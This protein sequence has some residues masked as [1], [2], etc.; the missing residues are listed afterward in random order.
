[1]AAVDSIHANDRHLFTTAAEAIADNEHVCKIVWNSNGIDIA[2]LVNTHRTNIDKEGTHSKWDVRAADGT[3]EKIWFLIVYELV[4][5]HKGNNETS[6]SAHA[7]L[8]GSVIRP[9][10]TSGGKQQPWGIYSE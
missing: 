8:K 9:Q 2:R 7:A 10:M 1:M 3:V 6:E 5:Y 4:G